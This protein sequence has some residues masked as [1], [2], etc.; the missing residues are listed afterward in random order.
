[1]CLIGNEKECQFFTGIGNGKLVGI[2]MVRDRQT[3]FRKVKKMHK[4]ANAATFKRIDHTCMAVF[5]AT[6]R[7]APG[8]EYETCIFGGNI[9]YFFRTKTKFVFIMILGHY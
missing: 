2:G 1:M 6:S 8:N 9:N 3:C 4:T 5:N 7:K